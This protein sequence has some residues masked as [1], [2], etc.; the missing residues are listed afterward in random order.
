M[1]PGSSGS[2]PF[3]NPVMLCS[4]TDITLTYACHTTTHTISICC[5]HK[6]RRMFQETRFRQVALVCVCPKICGLNRTFSSGRQPEQSHLTALRD[7][8]RNTYG[9]CLEHV[10]LTLF[11]PFIPPLRPH[12]HMHVCQNKNY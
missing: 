7:K 1:P 10:R 6:R 3:H 4:V 8:D 5:G 12:L 11:S 9:F 2:P